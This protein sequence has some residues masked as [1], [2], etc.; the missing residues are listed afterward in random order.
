MQRVR[1]DKIKFQSDAV[2]EITLPKG[3]YLQRVELHLKG[4][5][6]TDDKSTIND[7]G[8][9]NAVKKVSLIA[10][11]ETIMEISGVS[12]A[13]KDI[14]D[15]RT[16]KDINRLDRQSIYLDCEDEDVSEDGMLSLLPTMHYSNLRLKIEFGKKEDIGTN[17]TINDIEVE[18]IA[19]VILPEE[20]LQ[21]LHDELKDNLEDDDYENEEQL[22]QA[23]QEGIEACLSSMT[24]RYVKEIQVNP[25]DQLGEVPI[26]IPEDGV[27]T[28]IMLMTKSGASLVD[29][30]IDTFSVKTQSAI[31][32]DEISFHASQNQDI[33][34]Y[35]LGK[36]VK[37]TTMIE[38]SGD[39]E[40]ESLILKAKIKKIYKDAKIVI[41]AQYTKLNPKIERILES[42]SMEG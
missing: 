25:P 11:S 8:L 24:T 2:K 14:Y 12:G 10:D 28:N 3:G 40:N 5:I 38:I 7:G 39:T 18:I 31:I 16:Y 29:D 13:V 23:I 32:V 37:G 41:V 22:E 17:I 36:E 6:K 26:T 21:T 1:V 30:M 35:S 15:Y 19:D 9:A 20:L 4:D 27:C 34:E 42:M 33:V